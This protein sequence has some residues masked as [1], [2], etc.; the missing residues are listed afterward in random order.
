MA[1]YQFEGK[2]FQVMVNGQTG[3]VAGQNPVAWWKI[4]VAIAAMLTPGVL[5]AL[6]GLPGLILGGAGIVLIVFGFA[7]F[8]LGGVGAIALY[9]KAIASEAA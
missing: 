5:L 1:A 9:R 4:W 7:L 6:I 2:V 3:L 8:L